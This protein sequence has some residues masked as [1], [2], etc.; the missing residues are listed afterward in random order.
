MNK[1]GA[2]R[3][4]RV[5]DCEY[6]FHDV[7][8]QKLIWGF[9][10]FGEYVMAKVA[11]IAELREELDKKPEWAENLNQDIGKLLSWVVEHREKVNQLIENQAKVLPE[12]KQQLELKLHEYLAYTSEMLDDRD[13]TSAPGLISISTKDQSRWN[14]ASY[15][16]KTYVLTPFCECVGNVHPCE[17]GQVQFTKDLEWWQRTAP[18]IARG[19]KLLTAG[20]QLAFA[21]MPLALQHDVFETIKDHVRFMGELTKHMELEANTQEAGEAEN[22]LKGELGGKDLRGLERESRLMRVALA[23]FLEETAPTNY[24]AHQWGSLRRVRTSDNSYRWLC[25]SCTNDLKA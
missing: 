16:K 15:F 7:D 17:D 10:T 8:P 4:Q 23:Q 2:I 11:S 5:L 1:T 20:L 9:S 24:R 12:I 19:S 13:Y 18:W 3:K 22:V 25:E 6:E 21:G 14:P